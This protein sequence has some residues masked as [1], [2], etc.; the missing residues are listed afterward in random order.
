MTREPLIPSLFHR[1]L[2]LLIGLMAMVMMVLGVQVVRLT[3]A[4]G[5]QRLDRAESVLAHRSFL[6]TYRG[7]LLDRHGRVLALDRPSYDIA[8]Q[9]DVITGDWI[10]EQAARQARRALGRAEWGTMSPE[11]R[12]GARDERVPAWQQRRRAM[13]EALS[14]LGGIDEVE[15]TRRLE[16]VRADVERIAQAVWRQQRERERLLHGD[17]DDD[18]SFRPRPILEQEDAHVI[19]AH[20]P[21][22]VAFELRRLAH[23]WPGMIEVRDSRR[24]EYP[25]S[26]AEVT[27]ERTSLPREIRSDTRSLIRVEGVADHLLGGMRGETW[28]EDVARR[29]FREHETGKLDLGGYRIGDAVGARGLELAFEDH[30]RGRR[31]M[32]DERRDTGEQRRTEPVPGGD[33]QLTIDVLLQA[34]IQAILAPEFGLCRV[35]PWHAND[36]LAAGRPLNAVAVVLEVATGD[37][38]AA[39]SMP[40]LAMGKSMSRIEA[41]VQNPWVNRATEAI[42]PPGSIIKPIV[43]AAAGDEN[44]YATGE[45]IECTGHFFEHTQEYA[46]CWIFRERYGFSTHGAIASE[47]GISRSCNIFFY[48]LADRL[49]MPRLLDWYE[50]FGLG[51]RLGMGLGDPGAPGSAV[52]VHGG[53][54]PD[55]EEV[56]RIRSGGEARSAT[57]FMGIGQGPIAWTPL[58]AANAYAQ[59]ARGG[60][61]RDATVLQHDPRGVPRNARSDRLVPPDVLASALEGL[62]QSVSEYHGTGHH[63]TYGVNDWEPIINAPAVTV[64]AK[65]GTAQAPPLRDADT[66]GDGTIDRDDDAVTGLDHSWFVGL[67]GPE[68]SGRPLHAIA[69]IVEYGG[70]GGR[71]AGPVANQIIRA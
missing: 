46:R 35:Q 64:W 44:V 3:V 30:L 10:L 36:R 51:H 53:I 48:T 18:G 41:A 63:I 8:V 15:F 26:V 20:V 66:N 33:L 61:V 21:D 43:L 12:R 42:Y 68:N 49:G 27:L 58:Q 31:G 24:R 16:A 56:A 59:L 67:V 34:R 50:Q 60:I 55:A 62:R 23:E 14:R 9:F 45:A 6:P 37:V 1:R 54:L 65:T 22:E 71:V 28:A 5:R 11:A 29:P 69:V 32:I 19:L 52:G 39:V 38:L 17:D 2:L 70:S 25:W 7:R 4:E 47:E 57:I 40:T 13:F